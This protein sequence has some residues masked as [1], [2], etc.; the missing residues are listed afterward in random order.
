M[1]TVY[2]VAVYILHRLQLTVVWLWSIRA[3]QT[4]RTNA[5]TSIR[6]LASWLGLLAGWLAITRYA[7]HCFHLCVFLLR[8]SAYQMLVLHARDQRPKMTIRTA[9]THIFQ[10]KARS[11]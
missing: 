1:C 6:S 10:V 4:E 2:T 8:R 11:K 5:R 7:S 9:Q 3:N